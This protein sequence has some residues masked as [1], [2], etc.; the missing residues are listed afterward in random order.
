MCRIIINI[1]SELI[2]ISDIK[3]ASVSVWGVFYCSVAGEEAHQG[4]LSQ[5]HVPC[6]APHQPQGPPYIL[7]TCPILPFP[8]VAHH[9]GGY[10]G[11]FLTLSTF[12]NTR[13]SVQ[14]TEAKLYCVF[15]F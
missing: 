10:V 5:P 9:H 7:P 4:L 3:S 12:S 14:N 13:Q 11:L 8:N 1:K 6:I 2:L 15:I